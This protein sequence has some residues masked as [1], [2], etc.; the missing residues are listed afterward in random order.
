VKV[1]CCVMGPLENNVYLLVDE[2]SGMAA[3]VD[4]GIDS[5]P[6]LERV[7]EAGWTLTAVINT[8]G[9]F[10]HVFCDAYYLEQTGAPL[11]IHADDLPLLQAL[12]EQAA[13]IGYPAPPIP[14]PGRLLADGDRI[15]LGDT[16]LAVIHTPGHTPGGICLL[17]EDI[18]ISGDTLFAGSIGRTDLPGGDT[19]TLL[20]SIRER[21]LPLPDATRVYPGHG[22]ATTIG[23]EREANPFLLEG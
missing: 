3:V 13:W 1:E 21:L 7:R 2:A 17:G 10:D 23:R 5:E 12:P 16:E 11:L 15:A 14:T 18:L 4:P 8:H 6:L 9:H 19:N 20:R 22:P